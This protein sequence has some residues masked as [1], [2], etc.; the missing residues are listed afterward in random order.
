MLAVQQQNADTGALNARTIASTRQRDVQR[1]DQFTQALQAAGNNPT[2][3][4]LAM[5]AYR[6]PE[7][8]EAMRRGWQTMDEGTRRREFQAAAN[9]TSAARGA[10]IAARRGDTAS[11]SGASRLPRS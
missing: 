7:F 10:A 1:Q 3:E 5:L 2:A 6:F 4:Q 9:I 11:A 8:S